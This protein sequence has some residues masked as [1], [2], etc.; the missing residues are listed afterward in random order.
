MPSSFA[1][2]LLQTMRLLHYVAALGGGLLLIL[3]TY[4][5]TVAFPGT[6][7]G[8]LEGKVTPAW[9]KLHHPRWS[10]DRV[11]RAEGPG[12]YR[13]LDSSSVLVQRRSGSQR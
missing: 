8:M 10:G 7:R 3:H 13:Q 2:E 1:A 11:H 12:L 5:G 9:A 4:L 6:A